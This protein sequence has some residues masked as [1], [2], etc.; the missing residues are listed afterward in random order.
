[1]LYL[2][3]DAAHIDKLLAQVVATAVVTVTTFAG[4]RAWTFRT[5]S[6]VAVADG[7]R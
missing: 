5:R 2:F 3:V 4:N 7:E 1:L 6:P